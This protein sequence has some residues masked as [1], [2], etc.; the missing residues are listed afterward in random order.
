MVLTLLDEH[1]DCDGTVVFAGEVEQPTC[2]STAFPTIP[3]CW[4][5]L[6]G[7]PAMHLLW[8]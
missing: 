5:L 7:K 8:K 1:H 4:W 6:L 2:L 3:V